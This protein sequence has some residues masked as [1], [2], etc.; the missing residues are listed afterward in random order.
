M[1][2]IHLLTLL[3]YSPEEIMELINLAKKLKEE[4]K[5]GI[6]HRHLEGK[7]VV[8]LFEKTA[9]GPDVLLR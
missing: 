7:N 4:K 9:R 5:K 3:D 2:Q 8:L 6:S 1:K